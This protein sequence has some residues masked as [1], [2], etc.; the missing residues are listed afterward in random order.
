MGVIIYTLS[1]Y[2]NLKGVT[3]GGIKAN[4][5]ARCPPTKSQAF[6]SPDDCGDRWLFV[7]IL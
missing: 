5:F 4:T 3:D 1:R 6:F 2:Y 7:L